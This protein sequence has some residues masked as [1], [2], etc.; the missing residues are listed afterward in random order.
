MS[1]KLSIFL[2]TWDG[3]GNLPPERELVRAL[4][5]RGHTVR[6]LAHDSV[7]DTLERD[8]VECLPLRGVR[9]YDSKEPMSREEEMPFVLKHIWYAKAFGSELL[10]NVDRLRP[11]LLL[12][13]VSLTYA[14]VAA[15]RSGL[16]TAV[17]CHFPY[18]LTVGPFAPLLD[19]RVGQ[20]NAYAAELG[21]EPFPSHLALIESLPLVLVCS[22]RAFDAVETT[23]PN[24][25]HVGPLRSGGERGSWR[26]RSSGRPLVLVGLSTS[27]QNQVPLL[28]RLCDALGGLDVEAVVTTGPAIDPALLTASDNTTLLPFVSH[29]E[30]LRSSDLLITHAGH[31][32]VM[33]GATHGVPMLCF[34]M[35]RDQP[36]NA[37]RVAQL[38]IGA[39][40]GAEAPASEIRQVIAAMLA[41]VVVTKR[42]KEFARSLAGHPGLEDAVDLVEGMADRRT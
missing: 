13:D 35:G 31:G 18:H 39:V 27:H 12:V 28:Q 9:H 32:T 4:I 5:A 8:G 15:R 7:R 22:Y 20:P 29:D 2:V 3:A 23:A 37:D 33:A 25:V 36:M 19:A 11:D 6:A 26:R 17:L 16:P 21:I 34:P 14:M 40:V 38:G 10:A 41:D 1:R 30:V 42:A 24:V